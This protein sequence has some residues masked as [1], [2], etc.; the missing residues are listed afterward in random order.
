[1]KKNQKSVL[2][3]TAIGLP[4]G[5][6][7]VPPPKNRHDNVPGVSESQELLY[8]FLIKNVN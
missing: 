1:M 7:R 5:H 2:G 4:K 6:G 3:L 8:L